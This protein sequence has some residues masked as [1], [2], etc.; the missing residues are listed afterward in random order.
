[1]SSL[2]DQ[3]ISIKASVSADSVSGWNEHH[4]TKPQTKSGDN[5]HRLFE[6]RYLWYRKG[7]GK[8]RTIKKIFNTRIVNERNTSIWKC[9]IAE[10]GL[11]SQFASALIFCFD[12]FS[13]SRQKSLLMATKLQDRNIRR[14]L[15]MQDVIRHW[16]DIWWCL[17]VAGAQLLGLGDESKSSAWRSWLSNNKLER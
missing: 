9:P 16:N 12:E 8:Q 11:T 14:H 13:L 10:V 3:I 6:V 17:S 4:W 5:L 15:S 2:R 7:T 1:M